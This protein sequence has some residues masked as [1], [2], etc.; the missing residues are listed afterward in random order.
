[1][2]ILAEARQPE[3]WAEVYDRVKVVAVITPAVAPDVL[4]LSDA[5]TVRVHFRSFDADD[6]MPYLPDAD[7][8][9]DAVVA[10]NRGTPRDGTLAETFVDV[11]AGGTT[12]STE[13]RVSHQPGDNYRVAAST[14]E[15]WL[16]GLHALQPSATG[17]LSETGAGI[18]P[19]LTVW[20]TLHLEI[21]SMPSAPLEADAPE[22][23]FITGQVVAIPPRA[24]GGLPTRIFVE[25]DVTD[26]PL[27]LADGSGDLSNG[28]GAGR[29]QFGW[30]SGMQVQGNGTDFVDSDAG[31]E[32]P[33]ALTNAA[34]TASISG[35]VFGW[36][37]ATRK[38]TIDLPTRPGIFD[39]GTME[40]WGSTWMV[41]TSGLGNVEVVADVAWPLALV[42]DDAAE[43]PFYPTSLYLSCSDSAGCNIFAQA[44]IRPA[45]DLVGTVTPPFKRNVRNL[46][47][48]VAAQLAAGREFPTHAS[49]WRA[50]LQGA[51]QSDVLRDMDPNMEGSYLGLTGGYDDQRGSLLFAE[52]I[53]DFQFCPRADQMDHTLV[54]ELGHQF[55]LFD[56]TGGVMDFSIEPHCDTVHDWFTAEH[57]AEIRA[58]GVRP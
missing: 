16:Q 20:R 53:A 40:V 15:T 24:G 50:Y 6:P 42:D 7:G 9:V 33:Y 25:P 36:D 17:E 37:R 18:S 48:D 1:M 56:R 3:P 14:A 12:A 22:R 11:P 27:G 30:L 49:F 47:A 13:L 54:H 58:K 26:P 31:F 55:G 28:G 39:G 41:A 46:I 19:L 52:S 43:T 57:L 29:F 44:Y 5:T 34:G 32:I 10:D 51:F 45:W 35:H 21:D 23:N 38:F 4:S 2:R 8:D